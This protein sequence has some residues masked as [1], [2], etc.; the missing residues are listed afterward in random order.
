MAFVPSKNYLNALRRLTLLYGPAFR[1]AGDDL[2]KQTAAIALAI[3]YVFRKH[4]K[5]TDQEQMRVVRAAI[6][7]SLDV[8]SVPETWVDVDIFMSAMIV[9]RDLTNNFGCCRKLGL[10]GG[11]VETATS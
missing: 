1:A 2:P 4:N 5:L 10:C 11:K 8:E 6:R 3:E 7:D 9:A